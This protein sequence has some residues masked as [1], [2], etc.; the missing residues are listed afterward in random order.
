M[1][2]AKNHDKESYH[3]SLGNTGLTHHRGQETWFLVI[4]MLLMIKKVVMTVSIINEIADFSDSLFY[5]RYSS[6]SFTHLSFSLRPT[7]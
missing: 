4:T 2:I 3:Q 6:E 7:Q 1:D 5:T